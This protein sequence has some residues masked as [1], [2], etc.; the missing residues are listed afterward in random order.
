[1]ALAPA[2][3]IAEITKAAG[4]EL[5]AEEMDDLLTELQERIAAQEAIGGLDDLDARVR[6]AADDYA[7]DMA[8]KATILKRNKAIQLRTFLEG[9]DKVRSQFGTKTAVG[10]SRGVESIL[11]GVAIRGKGTRNSAAL[12]QDTLHDLYL[13]G[14]TS[15]LH[16]NG[17]LEVYNS[18]TQDREIAKALGARSREKPV[19][20]G[21]TKEADKIAEII[22]KYQEL[23]RTDANKVGA[24]IKKIEGY[25]TRQSHDIYAIRKAGYEAW[26]DFTLPKLDA[27]RT[28]GSADPEQFL[29]GAWQGLASGVHMK[30]AEASGMSLTRNVAKGLSEERVLHF[31]PDEWFDYNERFG[32]KSIRESV[33]ASLERM[34]KD[35]GLMRFLGPNPELGFDRLTKGVMNEIADP[36]EQ[37]KFRGLIDGKLRN[38][39]LELTGATR[40]PGNRVGAT[41]ASNV[42]AVTNMAKLGFAIASQLGDVP[43]YASEMKYQGRGFLSGMAESLS[44]IGKGVKPKE[45]AQLYKMLGVYFDSMNANI[46]S[47]FSAADD[48]APGFISRLQQRFFR[49]NLLRWW[50][51]SQ[52]ASAV[53]SFSHHLAANAGKEFEKLPPELQNVLGLFGLGKRQWDV[54]KNAVHEAEDGRRYLAPELIEALPDS[55]FEKFLKDDGIRPT[56]ARIATAKREIADQVRGYFLDRASYAQLTPDVRTRSTMLQ[57]TRPGTATGE[58]MRFI[59]QFKSFPIAAAQKVIGRELYGRGAS[60]DARMWNVYQRGNGQF[61]GIA[62]LVLWGALFGYASMTAK[63]LAKGRTPRNPLDWKTLLAAMGQSGGLGIYSDF[64]F[65]EANR[66]GGGLPATILGPAIGGTGSDLYNIFTTLRDQSTKHPEREAAAQAFRTAINNTPYMN[67]FYVKPVMDYL[68]LNRVSEALSPGS[69]KRLERRVQKENGQ[70]FLVRPSAYAGH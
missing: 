4:R 22:S 53:M 66:F 6:K 31:K 35:T 30:T 7:Q 14:L 55:Y 40:I 21:V 68:I 46:I 57:G 3:C 44:A 62:T 19:P 52:R 37:Q 63:D 42:R 65:G 36:A 49:A 47:R 17:L 64:L 58:A 38:R 16:Q 61:L 43:V 59:M 5:S 34:A 11:N 70:T 10:A 12:A 45:R 32:L 56:P 33:E 28:F 69:L 1:M 23:A 26:R 41:V 27:V 25:I 9:M 54:L 48:G 24:W 51:D 50:A 29:R 8:A 15:E 13:S 20:S 39:M 2:S 18:G 60:A 67:L